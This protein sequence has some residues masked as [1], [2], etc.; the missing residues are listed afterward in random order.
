MK[1]PKIYSDEL[2]DQRVVKLLLPLPLIR[3]M[4]HLLLDGVGGFST[5]NEFVRDYMLPA[6][7]AGVLCR[8]DDPLTVPLARPLVAKTL[9]DIARIESADAVAHASTAGEPGGSTFATLVNER[10]ENI[11]AR[12]LHTVME[13][14]AGDTPPPQGAHVDSLVMGEDRGS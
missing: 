10:T 7:R 2:R 3:Q 5:R 14:L 1:R 13:R 6:L 11:G 4:D 12:R 9:I 8:A